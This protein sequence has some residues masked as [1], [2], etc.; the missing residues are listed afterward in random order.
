MDDRVWVKERVDGEIIK[1][2]L[3]EYNLSPLQATILGRRGFS[4]ANDVKFFLEQELSYLHNPFLFD[5]ME[6]AVDRI[7]DAASEGEKVRIFG[8]RDVD[9]ITSTALLVEELRTLDLDVSFSLPKGDEPY[10]LLQSGVEEAA[11]DH[12]TLIITVDCGISNVE[13]ITLANSLGIDVIVLDHHIDG[14]ELPP[15]LAIINPNMSGSEY[16]F[17]HLAGVGVAAKLIWALRFAQTEFYRQEIILLHAQ[18]GNDTVIIQAMKVNNLLVTERIIE[19]INPG[20]VTA[21]RSKALSFLSCNLPILVL[22]AHTEHAQLT[23]AFGKSVDIHLLDMRAEMEAVLPPVKNRGLFALTHLSRAARYAEGGRDE[24]TALHSLFVAY[25][26]KKTPALDKEY[27]KLLDLVAIGTVADLM[28]LKDENVLLVKRGLNLLATSPRPSLVPFLASLGLLNKRISSTDISWKLAPPI[29]ATGRLGTPTVALNMLLSKD[30]VEI[31]SLSVEV[32]KMNT[33]RQ[34]LSEDT[35]T[36]IQ[37]KA[38]DSFE[39]TGSKMV[40]VHGEAIEMGIAGSLASR[41]LKAFN[42]PALVLSSSHDGRIKGSMRANEGTIHARDFLQHFDELDSFF[43]YY[44]GHANAA[45]FTMESAKLDAFITTLYDYIDTIDCLEETKKEFFID[46]T[47]S[48][49]DMNPDLIKLVEFF[50]PYGEGNRPLIFEI[51]GAI[52]EDIQYMNNNQGGDRHL[53]LTVGYGQYRWPAVYW[54]AAALVGTVFN[55]GSAVNILF[56]LARNYFQGNEKLQLTIV[57][58]KPTPSS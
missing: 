38:K 18:P 28:E 14:D 58:L 13:E 35:W 15:A 53:K 11:R 32:L 49:D 12:V 43:I 31:E 52:I 33:E 1:R 34:R 45:G 16:P 10:G 3:E 42:V 4:K 9:G 46:A 40:V 5:E 21:E 36:T 24:L 8:D 26:L 27:D 17:A 6:D 25:V 55:R 56:R 54:S 51:Q 44:G 29:N 39:Q 37:P 22:D 2:L 19:E 48:E 20:I 50:E 57:D 23:K 30:P 47:V 7:L 41:L